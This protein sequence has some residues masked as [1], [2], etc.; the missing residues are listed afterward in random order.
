MV[1]PSNLNNSR[2]I[3]SCIIREETFDGNVSPPLISQAEFNGVQSLLFNILQDSQPEKVSGLLRTKAILQEGISLAREET[4][5]T[6]LETLADVNV[7]ALLMKG[8]PL[9]YQVYSSPGLRPCVDTDLLVP[10]EQIDRV[11]SVLCDLE[12]EIIFGDETPDISQQF[13]ARR[14]FEAGHALD[15]DIHYSINN[16]LAYAKLFLFEEL[17]ERSEPLP[18]LGEHACALGLADAFLLACIHRGGHLANGEPDK[19]IWLYDIHLMLEQMDQDRENQLIELI[20]GKS[21][22]AICKTGVDA[23]VSAFHS[24]VPENLNRILSQ[25]TSA[26]PLIGDPVTILWQSFQSLPDLKSRRTFLRQLFFPSAEYM[27]KKYPNSG[28]WL[29]FLYARRAFE[30]LASRMK[31]RR[32]IRKETL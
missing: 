24:R 11:K 14:N 27:R 26:K 25:V 9:G 8:V 1:E 5:T 31:I 3:L 28:M 19:L 23:T 18:Q 22:H 16:Q 6:L 4:L 7:P 10:K 2:E 30:G 15:L 12:F 20:E 32:N 29:P 21:L 13:T 17:M